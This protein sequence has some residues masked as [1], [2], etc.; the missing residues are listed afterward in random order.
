MTQP[1]TQPN[2][3]Q[4]SVQLARRYYPEAAVGGF[5]RVDWSVQFWSQVGSLLKPDFQ[6]LDFGAGRGEHIVDDP[7]EWRRNLANLKGRCARLTGCDVSRAVLENPFLDQADLIGHD[8]NLPYPNESFD[9]IV[10]RMVF[11][12][13]PDP[14]TSVAELKRVLKPGGWIAAV[15]PNKWG[16]VAL[17]S[18]MVP[19]AL[20]ARVLKNVQPG[21]K[22]EDIFPTHYRLNSATDLRHHFEP[23]C[24]L[25]LCRTS[26]EPAYHFGSAAV[27]RAMM[28]VHALLP[29]FFHTAILAFIHKKRA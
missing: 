18:R 20:H 11:E 12:H 27:Y 29:A 28:A 24:T 23:E 2:H 15:T 17:A 8:G 13:L 14:A 1:Q 4:R 19:N 25:H 7:V 10:S 5:S 9:L 22:E 3:A 6:V 21:R 16:Y 26:S